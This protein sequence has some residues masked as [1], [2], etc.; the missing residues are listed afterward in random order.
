LLGALSEPARGPSFDV[1]A[2]GDAFRH[3][4]A[5][6]SPLL[7]EL[8]DAAIVGKLLAAAR[9]PR[10]AFDDTLWAETV[11]RC[12]AAAIRQSARADELARLLEPLYLGRL[13][14]FLDQ[15]E[16]ARAPDPFEPLALA[17][18][19]QKLAFVAGLVDQEKR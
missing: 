4:V 11:F 12:L 7:G 19:T 13:A 15:E 2:L 3:G 14:A 8:V 6:L 5:A 17:F 16:A 10:L 18:E 9:A 1:A